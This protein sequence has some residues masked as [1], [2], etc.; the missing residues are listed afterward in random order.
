MFL[1][2]EE[3]VTTIYMLAHFHFHSTATSSDILKAQE[4]D[5]FVSMLPFP[6]WNSGKI[7]KLCVFVI[8]HCVT[9]LFCFI[10]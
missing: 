5:G 3:W 4:H 6:M 10:R 1:L 9:V 2:K 7:S 8:F